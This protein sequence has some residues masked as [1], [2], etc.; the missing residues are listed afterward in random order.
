MATAAMDVGRA[1]DLR[2]MLASLEEAPL[3][4]AQFVYEPK[5]DGI[6][7]LVDLKPKRAG[8]VR[9]WSRLGNDKTGQFPKLTDAL[10]RRAEKIKAP[11]IL[12]GEI[13]ALDA[14]GEPVGF[15]ELQRIEQTRQPVGFIAFDIL[16]DGAQDLRALPWSARRARL[17]YVFANA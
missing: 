2:P 12:D 15:Q 4:D 6:R 13:V 7:A 5:Y 10:Q 9:I 8:G 11:V 1:H 16:R 14:S 3:Q 17:D